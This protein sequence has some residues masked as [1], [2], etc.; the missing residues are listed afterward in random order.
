MFL[1]INISK[2]CRLLNIISVI[3]NGTTTH[4]AGYSHFV[5]EAK[6]F[7]ITKSHSS[8][9]RTVVLKVS[10]ISHK[11]TCDGVH[12]HFMLQV[13]RPENLFNIDLP[14]FSSQY[15]GMF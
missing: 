3:F 6:E 12:F 1:R 11:N 13:Y 2:F 8:I 14:V 10:Q 5:R 4:L 9:C 7:K 15:C